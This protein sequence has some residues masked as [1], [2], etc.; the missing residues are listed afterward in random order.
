MGTVNPKGTSQMRG[1]L[2]STF[3]KNNRGAVRITL[4][5]E[6]GICGNRRKF[7]LGLSEGDFL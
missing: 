4:V 7:F 2:R 6:K 3:I 5:L 1:Q